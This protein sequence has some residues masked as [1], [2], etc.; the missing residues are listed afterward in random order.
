MYRT[1]LALTLL[2]AALATTGRAADL[3]K[4]LVGLSVQFTEAMI[5]GDTTLLDRIMDD[6]W[7]L[8]TP[9]GDVIGKS[10][11]LKEYSDGITKCE[12]MDKSDVMVRVYGDAATVSGRIR[13]SIK[14]E[15]RQV[16]GDDRF[17][18]VYVRR[19]GGWRNVSTQATRITTRKDEP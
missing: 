14:V 8:I 12:A 6:H 11:F 3:E 5:A 13:T 16:G 1:L 4:E 18:E 15:G 19:D 10:Q 17:T 7:T 2:A 9:N